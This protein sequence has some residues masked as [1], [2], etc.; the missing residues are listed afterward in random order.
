MSEAFNASSCFDD[1]V[2]KKETVGL[3]VIGTLFVIGTSLSFLPQMLKISRRRSSKGVSLLFAICAATAGSFNMTG[4]MLNKRKILQCCP[5]W[6]FQLCNERALPLYLLFF[7]AFCTSV[8]FLLVVSFRPRDKLRISIQD[9]LAPTKKNRSVTF[10]MC[11]FAAM[12]VMQIFFP[13]MFAFNIFGLHTNV[14]MDVDLLGTIFSG[15]ASA[16]TCVQFMPQV[17][18]TYKLKSLGSF[19]AVTLIIQSLG[20][21]GF[22][23]Y[24]LFGGNEPVSSFLPPVV[25]SSFQITL[26]IMETYYKC[27]KKNYRSSIEL[28]SARASIVETQVLLD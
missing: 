11:G 23:A 25:A 16:I 9:D 10:A 24:L 28:S 20:G 15:V 7:Q 27:T 22:G 1:D 21:I 26:L 13:C 3:V 2:F 6:G 8:V 12:I 19:S 5:R 14:A 4:T 17:Y 18:T